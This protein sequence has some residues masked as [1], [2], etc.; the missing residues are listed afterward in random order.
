MYIL[1]WKL[2]GILAVSETG[3]IFVRMD[4]RGSGCDSV[5]Q[6]DLGL[7]ST[8]AGESA[9]PK[10]PSVRCACLTLRTWESTQGPALPPSLDPSMTLMFPEAQLEKETWLEALGT[11]QHSCGGWYHLP[12]VAV[13]EPWRPAVKTFMLMHRIYIFVRNIFHWQRL[14]LSDRCP[15]IYV[16]ISLFF[17]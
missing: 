4:E 5:L 16:R 2:W 11:I 6:S 7:A 13:P 3:E 17:P 9:W 1:S 8:C 14:H 12:A 15:G 10:T